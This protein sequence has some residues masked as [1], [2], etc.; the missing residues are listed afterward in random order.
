VL[1]SKSENSH[2]RETISM[3]SVWYLPHNKQNA[4]CAEQRKNI[5]RCK[6]KRSSYI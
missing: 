1:C 3:C 6:E 2:R 5:K 4:K